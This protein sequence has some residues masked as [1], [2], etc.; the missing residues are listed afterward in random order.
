MQGKNYI[1][2]F[3]GEVTDKEL[4]GKAVEDCCDIQLVDA[5]H[6]FIKI[7]VKED[8]SY[9]YYYSLD[10][11]SYTDLGRTQTLERATWTG[12]KICLWSVNMNN[13]GSG[14]GY[15]RY[16]WVYITDDTAKEQ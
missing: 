6:V 9:N 3:K 10:G 14:N 13:K 12:A 8:K 16:D 2:M 15:G 11:V 4:E 7:V 5:A 1:V